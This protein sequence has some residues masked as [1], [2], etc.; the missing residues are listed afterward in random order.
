MC[1][2]GDGLHSTGENLFFVALP[3]IEKM[4]TPFLLKVVLQAIDHCYRVLT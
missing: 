3:N 2:L 1:S 4:Q